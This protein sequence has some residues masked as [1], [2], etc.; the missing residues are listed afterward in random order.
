NDTDTLYPRL[1]VFAYPKV[2]QTNP[3]ARI[4]VVCAAGGCTRWLDIPGDPR[5]HYLARMDWADNSSDI[6]VQQLNRLQNENHVLLACASSGRVS[7]VMVERDGAWVD[8]EGDKLHRIDKG[9]SFVWLSE[10]DGWRHLYAVSHEGET[11]R[12]ITSGA[13]D[14]IALEAVDEA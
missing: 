2:G 5:N 10:R 3:S 14:I 7:M 4:G 1:T 12:R 8:I 13:F 11:V 9:K 6:I